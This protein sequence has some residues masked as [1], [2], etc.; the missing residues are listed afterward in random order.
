MANKLKWPSFWQKRYK[1]HLGED[2][3]LIFLLNYFLANFHF[4]GHFLPNHLIYFIKK[5]CNIAV[6]NV[7][8]TL[9]HYDIVI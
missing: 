1:F 5:K 7:T 8:L 4:M 6:I 2:I 9:N 3:H